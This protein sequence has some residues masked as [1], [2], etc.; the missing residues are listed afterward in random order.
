MK[1]QRKPAT[2]AA[3]WL[4]KKENGLNAALS[5]SCLGYAQTSAKTSAYHGGGWRTAKR[6]CGVAAGMAGN[7]SIDRGGWHRLAE[8]TA[9]SAGESAVKTSGVT[10]GGNRPR[11]GSSA[12]SAVGGGGAVTGCCQ[13]ANLAE[14]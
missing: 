5:E 1:T 8:V 10:R 2:K 4:M 9:A 14:K 7:M 13:S 12:V 3:I 11:H 6:Q